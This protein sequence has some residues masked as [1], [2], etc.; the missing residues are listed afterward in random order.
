MDP[1]DLILQTVRAA[2]NGERSAWNFLY[3]YCYANLYAT[4]LRIC[5]ASDESKDLVQDTFVT[6]Y[7]KLS[8]LK[9]PANFQ[10]WIHK[11]LQRNCYRALVKSK[12]HL[13][14]ELTA[15]YEAQSLLDNT[16]QLFD[17]SCY[18]NQLYSILGELSAPL[19]SV[20]LLRYFSSFHSYQDIA[21]IL[22]VPVGTVRSRLNQARQKLMEKWNESSGLNSSALDENH[23]WN[24]F[25]HELY[26]GL[27]YNETDKSRLLNHLDRNVAITFPG[28]NL[29]VGVSPFEHLIADD[30]RHGSWLKPVQIISCNKIS[31]IEVK[32]FNSPEH[33][34]HCPP[35]SVAV[36]YRKNAEVSHM[37]LHLAF[38]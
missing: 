25:Y 27:H 4:A 18:R 35:K 19:L 2:Q 26:S 5:G 34:Q 22:S 29:Q 3:Q 20:V 6:A 14:K 23:K 12:Q 30:L 38:S 24:Q 10:A 28:N 17:Q 8:S 15:F 21:E 32:H 9:E 11:I 13:K 37:S 33:P 36:L 1:R 16:E 31:I 7:L